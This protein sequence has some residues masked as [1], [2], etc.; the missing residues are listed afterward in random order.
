MTHSVHAPKSAVHLPVVPSPDAYGEYSYSKLRRF[1]QCPRSYELQ[2]VDWMPPA[3]SPESELGVV[4]HQVLER[5]VRD[6]VR[7]GA[8]RPLDAPRAAAEYR[9]AWCNSH[10]SDPGMFAEGL[11]L[12]GRW[13]AREG[14]VHPS[15]VLAVEQE[16]FIEVDG[17]RVV[18][19]IDRV[20]RNGSDAIRIRDYKSCRI[21]PTR[22]EVEESLQLGI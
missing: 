9:L 21:P 2:Y 11:G 7:A 3:A 22:Q 17:V 1:A 20:D 8:A 10:L 4:L 19:A 18:G 5:L 14:V 6:H 15:E 16:F 13:I 12:V